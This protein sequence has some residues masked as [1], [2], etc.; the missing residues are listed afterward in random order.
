MQNYVSRHTYS[1]WFPV[2][3]TEYSVIV[4]VILGPLNFKEKV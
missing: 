2:D 1:A 3:V 4:R